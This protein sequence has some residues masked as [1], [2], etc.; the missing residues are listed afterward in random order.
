MRNHR[1]NEYEHKAPSFSP[2]ASNAEHKW[3]FGVLHLKF[4]FRYLRNPHTIDDNQSLTSLSRDTNI[5]WDLTGWMLDPPSTSFPNQVLLTAHG[6][7]PAESVTA[8][9]HGV[10]VN[11]QF[12]GTCRYAPLCI[13]SSVSLAWFASFKCPLIGCTVTVSCFNCPPWYLIVAYLTPQPWG[14]NL[15]SGSQNQS[16]VTSFFACF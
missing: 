10:L 8:E 11:W 7:P 15:L 12:L 4:E 16:P 5:W 2:Y 1:W 13:S 14:E 6:S 3:A 9:L